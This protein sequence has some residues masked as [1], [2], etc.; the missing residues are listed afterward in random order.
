MQRSKVFASWRAREQEWI[1][2]RWEEE[3]P[4]KV[5]PRS[6]RNQEDIEP[7]S[8]WLKRIKGGVCAISEEAK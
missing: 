2:G 7:S 1:V 4:L 3:T 8:R 6:Q 5:K